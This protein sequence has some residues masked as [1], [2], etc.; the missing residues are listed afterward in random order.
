[1]PVFRPGRELELAISNE[2]RWKIENAGLPAQ[3]NEGN[4]FQ[5]QKGKT[6]VTTG[7]PELESNYDVSKTLNL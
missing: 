7:R 4:K 1:M 3:T 5:R 2:H 6:L